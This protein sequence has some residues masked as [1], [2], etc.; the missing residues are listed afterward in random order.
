MLLHRPMHAPMHDQ[1]AGRVLLTLQDVAVAVMST[2]SESKM[3]FSRK[4][5]CFLFVLQYSRTTA[6]LP[7]YGSVAR[8]NRHPGNLKNNVN[9]AST[10]SL[11]SL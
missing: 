7:D 9:I 2:Q 5:M 4:K 3:F 10:F 6:E 11:A 8:C 1:R